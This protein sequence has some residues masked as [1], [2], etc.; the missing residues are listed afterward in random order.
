MHN[1]QRAKQQTYSSDY[2]G[3]NRQMQDTSHTV[4]TLN[5]LSGSFF[6]L[7]LSE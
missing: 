7:K 1:L 5:L 4:S 2:A 3:T 6:Q